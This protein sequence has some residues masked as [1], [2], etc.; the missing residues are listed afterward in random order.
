MFLFCNIKICFFVLETFSFFS[1]FFFFFFSNFFFFFF[2]LS[3]FVDLLSKDFPTNLEITAETKLATSGD[4]TGSQKSKVTRNADGSLVGSIAPKWN[5]VSYGVTILATLHTS[6]K[7]ELEASLKDKVL[8]GL[9]STLKVNAK[10][11]DAVGSQK[12]AQSVSAEFEYLH[13][14]AAAALSVD[15]LAPKPQVSLGLTGKREQWTAGVEAKYSV[16]AATDLAALAAALHY[17]GSNWAATF[18][19]AAAEGAR[20]QVTYT[21]RVH[22]KVDDALQVAAELSWAADAEKAAPVLVVGGQFKGARSDLKAKV[23]TTGRVGLAYTQDLNYF[24]S[25]T[26]GLDLNAADSKDHKLGLALKIHD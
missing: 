4:V 6:K 22:H 11:F 26:L 19:R 24:A 5:L 13:E 8:A 7:L 9:K 25:A 18:T 16:G 12:D 21:A 15:L 23:G 20:A 2:Q 10:S 1:R 17:A 14:Y 3:Q